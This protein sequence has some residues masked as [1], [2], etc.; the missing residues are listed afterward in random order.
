MSEES[1][2]LVK[3]DYIYEE[4]HPDGFIMYENEKYTSLYDFYNRISKK[5]KIVCNYSSMLIQ[6]GNTNINCSKAKEYIRRYI[7]LDKCREPDILKIYYKELKG[8][9]HTIEDKINDMYQEKNKLQETEK[10]ILQEIENKR[11]CYDLL[12]QLKNN[13]DEN[14][15]DWSN[16]EKSEFADEIFGI[17]KNFIEN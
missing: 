8:K 2:L 15:K 7:N 17:M 6:E 9:I 3:C 5:Y 4:L 10:N 13:L 12:N 11:K 14:I 16:G 1:K